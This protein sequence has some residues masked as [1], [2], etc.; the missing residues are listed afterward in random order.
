MLGFEEE[1]FIECFPHCPTGK[2][3]HSTEKMQQMM[4]IYQIDR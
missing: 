4:M 1:L 3:K 2:I